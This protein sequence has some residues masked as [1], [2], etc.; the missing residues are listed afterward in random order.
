MNWKTFFLW[1][2][3]LSAL[4]G[5]IVFLGY[6]FND[7]TYKIQFDTNGGSAIE[8]LEVKKNTKVA[9]LPISIKDGYEFQGW[10]LNDILFDLNKEITSDIKL[11]AKWEAV[12]NQVFKISFDTLDDNVI[13]DIEVNKDSKIDLPE[14]VRDDYEFQG[15]YYQNK[16]FS[17]DNIEI[18]KNITLVAKWRKIIE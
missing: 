10:F 12:Y 18:N 3:L 13:T 8:S 6:I 5:G 16:E 2:L 1:I 4:G 9:K 11:V 14:L 7:N 17:L 15:W